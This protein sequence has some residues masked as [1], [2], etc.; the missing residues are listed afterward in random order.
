[1]ASPKTVFITGCSAG[2]IGEALAREFHTR[3]HTVFATARDVAKM[4]A[5]AEL[6][7]T[8]LQVDVLSEASVASAAEQVRKASPRGLDVLINNAGVTHA[9]P[10]TDCTAADLR[11]VMDTNV[12]AVMAVTQALLPLLIEAR[13]VVA[14]LGSIN[15]VV[16]PPYHAAYNASKAALRAWGDTLRVELAPFGVRVVTVVAGSVSSHLFDNAPESQLPDGSRY[17]PLAGR[18]KERD[19]LKSAKWGPADEFAKQVAGDLLRPT[20]KPVLWRGNLSTMA[21]L[22]SIFAWVGSMVSVPPSRFNAE[23]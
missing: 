14:S 19:Y 17:A 8:T 13:G 4:A 10:F 7:V 9:M 16:L 21:W 22:M 2:G 20:P 23:D 6:G 12:L 5:L 11:R 3:G 18:I 15:Q 1:M